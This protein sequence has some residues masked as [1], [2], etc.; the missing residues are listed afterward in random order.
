[1]VTNRRLDFDVM[2]Q[3]VS[4]A[5]YALYELVRRSVALGLRICLARRNWCVERPAEERATARA[6]QHSPGGAA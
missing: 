3:I 2:E 4:D 5:Y 6:D 1:M